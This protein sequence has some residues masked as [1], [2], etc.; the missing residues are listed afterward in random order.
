MRQK[1]PL[2]SLHFDADKEDQ[3]VKMEEQKIKLIQIGKVK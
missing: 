3:L 2:S 1:W